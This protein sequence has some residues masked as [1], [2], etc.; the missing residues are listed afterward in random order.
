M[1]RQE[2]KTR[3]KGLPPKVQLQL[4]NDEIRKIPVIDKVGNKPLWFNDTKTLKLYSSSLINLPSGLPVGSPYLTSEIT[5]TMNV[6]GNVL[7]QNIDTFLHTTSFATNSFAPFVDHGNAAV[8]APNDP[9]Y[10]VGTS[11]DIVGEGFDQPL[12][13]KSKFE[14]DLTPSVDHSFGIQ[15][16][17]S[18]SNNYPM[19]YWNKVTRKYEGIGTG[20]EFANSSYQGTDTSAM[21]TFLEEQCIGFGNSLD[22][23]SVNSGILSASFLVGNP[24]SNFG[25]PTA[26]K[27]NASSSNLVSMKDYIS[28]PF[29]VEKVVL[30]F[31]GSLALNDYFTST[32]GSISSFFVLN[33]RKTFDKTV[34]QNVEYYSGSLPSAGNQPLSLKHSVSIGGYN[35]DLVTWLQFSAIPDIP[36]VVY[37]NGMSRDYNYVPVTTIGTKVQFNNQLIVSGVMKS[38]FGYQRALVQTVN[39]ASINDLQTCEF[40]ETFETSGRN[41]LSERGRSWLNPI[42]TA[43]PFGKGRDGY[44]AGF[45]PFFSVNKTYSKQNPYLLLP[46]DNLVFGWQVPIAP[47]Y[48]GDSSGNSTYAGVGPQFTFSKQGINKIV[49]YGS[50]LR[51][52]K[53]Y[54]TSFEQSKPTDLISEDI[55]S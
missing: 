8:D 25:F 12:W 11:V 7:P 30:F 22:N 5:T 21:I 23:G 18:S 27:Y 6:S 33:Q 20:K 26:G 24:I 45:T 46:T 3:V 51:S 31:S 36:S 48:V 10:A 42:Q 37:I 34:Q 35:R 54:H 4:R 17:L 2:K 40:Y 38:V 53:E 47:R 43:E 52:G 15:N 9:F 55:G 14:I 29:L 39:N 50:L 19:A 44:S 49:F 1:S 41:L 13:S 32:H 16:F 28:E